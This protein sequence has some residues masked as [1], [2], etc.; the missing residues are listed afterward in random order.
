VPTIVAGGAFRHGQHLAFDEKNNI[1]LANLFVS[2]GQ[3]MGME[4]DRFGTST[5][6]GVSGFEVLG[7]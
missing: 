7:S 5:S 6:S 4:M 1:P 2:L 3:H